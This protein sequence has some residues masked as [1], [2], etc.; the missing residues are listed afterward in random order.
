MRGHSTDADKT[1]SPAPVAAA[2]T[3]APKGE[4]SAAEKRRKRLEA[5]KVR[6]TRSSR[7]LLRP[8]GRLVDR[9]GG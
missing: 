6:A 7:A 1:A 3:E 5:W 4:E 9:G 8:R 2:G